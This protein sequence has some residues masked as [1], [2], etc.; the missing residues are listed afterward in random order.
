MPGRGRDCR[1]GRVSGLVVAGAVV[2]TGACRADAACG[3]EL[4][5]D[6]LLGDGDE[7]LDQLEVLTVLADEVLRLG[8]FTR[9][10]SARLGARIRPGGPTGTNTARDGEDDDA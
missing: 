10:W 6:T 1:P 5:D 8:A 9:A 2:P 4:F 7:T 3:G